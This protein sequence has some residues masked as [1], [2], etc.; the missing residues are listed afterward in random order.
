MKVKV[1]DLAATVEKT[2]SDYAD[3]VND[4]VKQ[5]IKDAG[6]EAAKELKTMGYADDRIMYVG[7]ARHVSFVRHSDL[8][9]GNVCF[10]EIFRK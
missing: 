3:D 10:D 4:I 6:K 5:E 1:D 8:S 2:I 9:D 7:L